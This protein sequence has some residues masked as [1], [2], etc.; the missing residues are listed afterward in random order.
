MW[1]VVS[2]GLQYDEQKRGGGEEETRESTQLCTPL[3]K[4]AHG[5][6]DH[7]NTLLENARR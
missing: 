5:T 7:T 6:D 2:A 4:G 3:E 1:G